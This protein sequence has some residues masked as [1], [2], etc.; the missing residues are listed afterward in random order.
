MQL[1]N[2]MTDKQQLQQTKLLL[3][4]P[5]PSVEQCKL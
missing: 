5:Q 4:P 2:N 1:T 3:H